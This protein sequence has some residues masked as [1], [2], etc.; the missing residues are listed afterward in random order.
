M[1][2]NTQLNS[3]VEQ[4]A[5]KSGVTSKETR[6]ALKKLKKGGMMSQLAPQ[7]ENQ[8]MNMNPNL[9]AKQRLR[10]KIKGMSSVRQSKFSKAVQYEKTRQEV[11][12]KKITRQDQEKMKQDQE[13][14]KKRN[15]MKRLKQL[16]KKLGTISD[17][18]YHECLR[19]IDQGTYVDEGDLNRCN[20]IV[21]LYSIQHKFK[22]KID[23]DELD[24]E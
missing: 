4:Q 18:L 19:K 10:Q 21:E 22:E 11:E 7:L 20:N 8:F 2:D 5:E 14:R 1:A 6:K 15:H 3:L 9:S 23:M 24:L 13:K 12:A 17:D 16:E